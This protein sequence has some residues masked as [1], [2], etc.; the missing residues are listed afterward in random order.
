MARVASMAQNR[1]RASP[2]SPV[3][4]WC[5]FR[6]HC[7]RRGSVI[8]SPIYCFRYYF[9]LGLDRD[10]QRHEL[11]LALPIFHITSTR[12]ADG[13]GLYGDACT[14]DLTVISGISGF[15]YSADLSY[16]PPIFF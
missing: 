16:S 14:E 12:R 10:F 8:P 2:I 7:G 4:F 9:V 11:T 6:G 1:T 3:G 5:R 13:V 15:D